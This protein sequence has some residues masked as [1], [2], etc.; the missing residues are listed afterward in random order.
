MTPEALEAI[1]RH[2][3]SCYPAEGCGVVLGTAG[4]GLRVLPL[5]N[6]YD[7]YAKADPAHFPRT[8]RT[9]YKLNELQLARELEAAAAQG[10]SLRCIFHSHVDVGAYFSSEDEDMAAPPP[11]RRPAWPGV[12]YLVVDVGGGKARGAKLFGWDGA[13]FS[14]LPL[15]S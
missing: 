4:G 15:N 14:E 11:D 6:V 2:V 1:F 7:R 3:E 9:A 10:E 8:S 5:P 13:R 12:V